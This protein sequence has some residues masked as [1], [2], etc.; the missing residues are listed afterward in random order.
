MSVVYTVIV[1]AY[2]LQNVVIVGEPAPVAPVVGCVHHPVRANDYLT[3]T[4]VLFI[5]CFIHG[6]ILAVLLLIPALI[7]ACTVSVKCC[8]IVCTSVL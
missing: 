1:C 5:L 4:L 7:C 6:N 2:N 3:A 8:K